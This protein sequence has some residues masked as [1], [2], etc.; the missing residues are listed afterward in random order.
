MHRTLVVVAVVALVVIIPV[1]LLV[2][3]KLPRSGYQPAWFLLYIV[4]T[5][6]LVSAAGALLDR[7]H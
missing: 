3:R 5:S 1:D 6:F 2:V 7:N 4:L